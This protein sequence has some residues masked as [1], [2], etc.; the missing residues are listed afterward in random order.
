MRLFL[1]VCRTIP[2]FKN[3]KQLEYNFLTV[4]FFLKSDGGSYPSPKDAGVVS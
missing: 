2:L 3:L 1:Y 4:E